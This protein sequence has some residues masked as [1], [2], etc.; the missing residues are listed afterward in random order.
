MKVLINIDVG[1]ICSAEY[2]ISH[3]GGNPSR[4]HVQILGAITTYI[5]SN[6]LRLKTE[7]TTRLY[8]QRNS[9]RRSR[10]RVRVALARPCEDR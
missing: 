4:L 3:F 2:A 7:H 5:Q 9:R 8:R 1:L 6:M 10:I